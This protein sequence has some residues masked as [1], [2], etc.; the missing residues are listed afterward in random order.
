MTRNEMTR[1]E[2]TRNEMTRNEMKKMD[3][4]IYP[5]ISNI[6]ELVK[7]GN[8]FIKML[9]VDGNIEAIYIFKKTCLYIEE[10]KEVIS[11]IASM[12]GFT[13]TREEF[14]RG[15][16]MSLWSIIK[17][18]NNFKYLTIEDISENTCIIN[19]LCIRTSPMVIS[20]M[21]YFFY[22]FA[23][24]PFKPEKCFIIN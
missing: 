18:N 7:S 1:N 13:F 5:E 20:P 11:C 15:F 12:N 6:I 3:I 22:N 8:L 16:K 14:I 10:G 17:E 2:M 21:A 19:N 24:S 9:V 4:V 23:Y